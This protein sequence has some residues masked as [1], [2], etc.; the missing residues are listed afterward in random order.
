MVPADRSVVAALGLLR[1]V[2]ASVRTP[3]AFRLWDG[4]AARVG[5]PGENRFTIVFRSRPVFRR[6]L[7]RPTPLRFGEAFI[8]GDIDIEGDLFAAM[9]AANAIEELRLP[10]GTRLAVLAS[11]LR[12]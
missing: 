3:L 12:I 10:L 1:Q 2:F 4:S 11:L 6:L 5:G 8:G 9:R 7:H